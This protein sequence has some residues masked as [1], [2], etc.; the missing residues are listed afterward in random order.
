MK[1]C[2]LLTCLFIGS[3][4][5]AQQLVYKPI[6]SAFGGDNYNYNW[7]L[8]S[9]NAQNQFKANSGFNNFK[10]NS[11]VGSFEDNL[12]RQLLNKLTTGLTGTGYNEGSYEPG[13]YNLGNLYVTIKDYYGGVNISVID[14]HTGEQT[15]INL[16]N[17]Y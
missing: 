3:Y 6:N 2:I 9:A 10:Q 5:N 1:K 4:I 8:N 16:P 12:H 7:L 15:N 11:A 14:T 17:S 13:V